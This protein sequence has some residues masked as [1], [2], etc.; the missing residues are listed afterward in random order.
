VITAEFKIKN[1]A[2]TKRRCGI[3]FRKIYFYQAIEPIPFL[4]FAI[5]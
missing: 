3:I 2:A 1:P 4:D 5:K